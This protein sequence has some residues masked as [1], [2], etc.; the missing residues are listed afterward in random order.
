MAD[1]H[2]VIG[3]TVGGLCDLWRKIVSYVRGQ[4]ELLVVVS[5]LMVAIFGVLYSKYSLEKTERSFALQQKL[6]EEESYQRYQ[7]SL[8]LA[9]RSIGEANNVQFEIGQSRA[10]EFLSKSSELRGHITLALRDFVWVIFGCF[11]NSG[12]LQVRIL[13]RR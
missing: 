10:I 1:V 9:S 2:K 13:R 12:K 7:S 8:S 11:H 4:L 6:Y 3:D 5:T